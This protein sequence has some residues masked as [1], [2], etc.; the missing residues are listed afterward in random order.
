M[1]KKFDTS[2]ADSQATLVD[3]ATPDQFDFDMYADYEKSFHKRCRSFWQADSGVLVY[4]RVRV[5]EVFSYDSKEMKKSLEWQLG[6]LMRSIDYKADI[7]NFLEPWYGIGTLAGAYGADY[8]WADG[9][10]PITKPLFQ[11]VT[12]ALNHNPSPIALS[13]IGK[14][15]LEMIEYFMD[16]TKGKLPVSFTDTQSPLNS[17]CNIVNISNFM[18]DTVMSPEIVK[19]LLD[20]V[21]DLLIEFT[22]K[23]I[24]LIGSNLASPGHGFASSREF[25]GIGISDDNVLMLS[26]DSYL[27]LAVP[28]LKKFGDS[29][30]GTVF[31]S[32]GDWS[33]RVKFVK[34]IK[35]LKM[36]DGAFSD[37]T[38]PKHNPAEPFNAFA[39]TGII[40]EAR[41]VG[42]AEEVIQKV[43]KLWQPGMKLIIVTYC[44]TP[45]E[46]EIVY[47]Q[48]HQICQ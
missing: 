32:C 20:Q 41:I 16:K 2:L 19:R 33:D 7:P 14:H 48:I 42:N 29:F 12:D 17:A 1:A 38:D 3:P 26:G 9:Q 34:Q 22:R 28:S 5:A 30:G 36:V 21:A 40:V 11:S 13:S 4:R 47:D 8:Y 45:K 15:T 39:N 35:G 37:E 10:A 23:Q 18:M 6:A 31:H 25:D 24:D 27:D 43:E 44:K 46:Q